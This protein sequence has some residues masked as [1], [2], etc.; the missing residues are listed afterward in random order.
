MNT[1]CKPRSSADHV[2]NFI[3]VF[4]RRVGIRRAGSLFAFA[5]S[6]LTEFK[7]AHLH[8]NCHHLFY[9]TEALDIDGGGMPSGHPACVIARRPVRSRPP[10]TGW[11]I[12]WRTRVGFVLKWLSNVG[13]MVRHPKSKSTRP[14]F[15]APGDGLPCNFIPLAAPRLEK[16]E[17]EVALMPL[18]SH[19]HFK[20][21]DGR[22]RIQEKENAAA[23]GQR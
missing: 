2:N 18:I 10:S 7:P 12:S 20:L 23:R 6:A 5:R 15:A 8:L 22:R 4:G 21:R 13:K 16:E 3:D 14:R 1:I 9:A 17:E 11:P 19:P